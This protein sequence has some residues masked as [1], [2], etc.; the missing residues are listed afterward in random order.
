MDE[1][2]KTVGRKPT[3]TSAEKKDIVNRYLIAN[4][5][6][7][8]VL[9]QH[10]ISE[11]L[12]KFARTLNEKYKN[13]RGYHFYSDDVRSYISMLVDDFSADNQAKQIGFAYIPLDLVAINQLAQS[14]R[15]PELIAVLREREDYLSNLY[16]KVAQAAVQNEFISSKFT[17]KAQELQ[18]QKTKLTALESEV[19]RLTIEAKHKDG[20]VNSLKNENRTL[21]RI[22]REKDDEISILSHNATMRGLGINDN[23]RSLVGREEAQLAEEQPKQEMSSNCK[24]IRLVPELDEE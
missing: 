18:E 2:K 7:P 1:T 12:A 21:K 23:L 13:V 24:V 11:N 22:I 14:H 16:N 6:D 5:Q 15:Y 3:L 4:G 9:I 20:E 8:A 17:M 10:G 19:A